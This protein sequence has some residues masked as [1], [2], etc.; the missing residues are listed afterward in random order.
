MAAEAG[1]KGGL[2]IA[3]NFDGQAACASYV[4]FDG[5]GGSPISYGDATFS[6]TAAGGSASV[7]LGDLDSGT[8]QLELQFYGDEAKTVKLNTYRELV[9]VSPGL[10]SRASRDIDLT[11]MYKI[12]YHNLPSG[13]VIEG[14]GTLPMNYSRKSSTITLPNIKTGGKYF[15]GYYTASDFNKDSKISQILGTSGRDVDLYP[16]FTDK[17]YVADA[18]SSTATGTQDDALDSIASAASIIKTA[19]DDTINWTIFIDGIL[20]GPQTLSM[21]GSSG[22]LPASITLKGARGP[23]GGVF[24]DGID[25]GWD[26]TSVPTSE[27]GSALTI[28]VGM[29]VPITM[30]DLLVKGGYA[31]N[32]GGIYLSKGYVTFESGMITTNKA[33]TNGGGVFICYDGFAT[34]EM[35]DGSIAGNHAGTSGGGVYIYARGIMGAGTFAMS[36]GTVSGNFAAESGTGYGHGVYVAPPDSKNRVAPYFGMSGFALVASDNDVYLAMSSL[37]DEARITVDGALTGEG[38]VATIT[39]VDDATSVGYKNSTVL[40]AQGSGS[41]LKSYKKFAVNPAPDGTVYYVDPDGRLTTTQPQTFDLYVQQDA[42]GSGTSASSPFGSIEEAANYIAANGNSGTVASIKIIGN[43]SGAQVLSGFNDSKAKQ[44]VIEGANGVDATSGTPLD[45]LTGGSGVEKTLTVNL[46]DVSVEIT[47]LRISGA[48]KTGLYVG[49]LNNA[50]TNVLLSEG[51][52]ITQNGT[53]SG[54]YNGG[55]VYITESSFVKTS[56]GCSITNNKAGANGGGVYCQ[57]RLSLFGGTIS[58]NQAVKGTGIYV[59]SNGALGMMGSGSVSSGNDIYLVNP[60]VSTYGGIAILGTLT[61]QSPVATITPH[62]YG[63]GTQLLESY[64]VLGPAPDIAEESQKFAVTQPS[65]SAVT[66]SI[67]TNGMLSDGSNTVSF[68]VAQN[69]SSSA[70]G[71]RG[72]PFDSLSDALDYIADNDYSG[73]D[74]IVKVDGLLPVSDHEVQHTVYISSFSGNSLTIEGAN[75]LENGI[76][77]DSISGDLQIYFDNYVLSK[78]TFRNICLTGSSS[79]NLIG[80]GDGEIGYYRT[81]VIF[82]SGVLIKGNTAEYSDQGA[83]FSINDYSSVTMKDGCEISGNYNTGY[84]SDGVYIDSYGTFNMEGGTIKDNKKSGNTSGTGVKVRGTFNISGGAVVASNNIVSLYSQYTNVTIADDL[85]A[86]G[87]VATIGP[88]TSGETGMYVTPAVLLS[89]VKSGL[90]SA[91]HNKFAVLP[92]SGMNWAV[93]DEGNLVP[94]GSG[95]GGTSGSWSAQ[96]VDWQGM[97]AASSIMGP[98]TK[99]PV[100]IK[101]TNNE[102]GFDYSS[103]DLDSLACSFVQLSLKKFQG[104]NM[105]GGGAIESSSLL[106]ENGGILLRVSN[107]GS[108]WGENVWECSITQGNG[109]FTPDTIATCYVTGSSNANGFVVFSNTD[110]ELA[111]ALPV[112]LAVVNYTQ[113]IDPSKITIECGGT[114]L[115]LEGGLMSLSNDADHYEEGHYYEYSIQGVVST[116]NKVI[117]VYYIG[118]LIKTM[119]VKRSGSTG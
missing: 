6:K 49:D 34:F 16:L 96:F 77:Q 23:T 99:E 50:Y 84:G 25:A 8:Y 11:A 95:G 104:M 81:N 15:V 70:A 106:S 116:N 88:A 93:D 118:T 36:G 31:T 86:D 55:G 63:N 29:T 111:G 54:D 64:N 3:I 61:A 7:T 103:V 53:G 74:V 26:G 110:S 92:K 108:S 30:K 33:T 20:S 105:S 73:Y 94:A 5:E 46:E 82:D 42:S 4:L 65:G 117:N 119:T 78:I 41:V 115:D 48:S 112:N 79:G 17:L 83:A 60:D 80:S 52:L 14:G 9:R 2:A 13:V 109:G 56:D 75:G 43:L 35:K 37:G 38:T 113:T 22:Q 19:D 47:N 62:V 1:A 32:G 21:D 10:T 67:N 68:Y 85:T 66:W 58:N 45:A 40:A 90:I 107:G 91:Y 76:P 89:E 27:I 51:T 71:S 100:Y 97:Q 44:I 114:Q 24:Q 28:K 69:G 102:S 57:G 98:G 12:T 72:D 39:G 59:D 87:I 101:L 18:G